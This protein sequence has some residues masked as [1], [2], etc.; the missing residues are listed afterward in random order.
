MV[1]LLPIV[2]GLGMMLVLAG[3]ASAPSEDEAAP[4][5]A[6]AS[7]VQVQLLVV[8]IDGERFR[9]TTD[10]RW[11]QSFLTNEARD[12]EVALSRTDDL[13]LEARR[14]LRS[15]PGIEFI[16]EPV[17]VV[18]PGSPA[19]VTTAM[20]TG[21]ALA[22]T[23]RPREVRE[24]VYEISPRIAF[25]HDQSGG[26]GEMNGVTFR[27]PAVRYGTVPLTVPAGEARAVRM[28]REIGSTIRPSDL[29]VFVFA[30][31]TPAG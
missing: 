26:T 10:A 17:V 29:Q 3:C 30:K 22:I 2:L 18:R 7:P 24:G 20:G 28:R 27:A 15:A 31:L 8:A 4:A 19:T 25:T 21:S 23:V 12:V 13:L 14:R 5:L 9:N 1:R 16:R 11:L 6:A